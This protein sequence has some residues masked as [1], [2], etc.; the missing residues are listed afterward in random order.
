M[1]TVPNV[2]LWPSAGRAGSVGSWS[3]GSLMRSGHQLK[4]P[5]SVAVDRDSDRSRR[6]VRVRTVHRD[7]SLVQPAR[8][9]ASLRIVAPVCMC[10]SRSLMY[11]VARGVTI[12]V[13]SHIQHMHVEVADQL[14]D[15][16]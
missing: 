11:A 16:G 10:G 7:V 2:P 13:V 1:H 12:I 5:R 4:V 6:I 3:E 9:C 14:Q 8:C 15:G